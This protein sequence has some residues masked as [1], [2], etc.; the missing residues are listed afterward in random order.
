MSSFTVLSFLFAAL[1]ALASAELL[2]EDAPALS[3]I[4]GH[5][6][7]IVKSKGAKKSTVAEISAADALA[8]MDGGGLSLMQGSQNRISASGQCENSKGGARRVSKKKANLDPAMFAAV[9][10]GVEDSFAALALFQKTRASKLKGDECNGA[11]SKD[12]AVDDAVLDQDADSSA[13][14][15]L[16]QQ[17]SSGKIRGKKDA[18]NSLPKK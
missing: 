6:R 18:G 3:L 13:T 17:E 10:D 15:N 16:L 11:R 1:L 7:K 12:A 2:H 8:D 9:A 5:A 14:L 4:Q